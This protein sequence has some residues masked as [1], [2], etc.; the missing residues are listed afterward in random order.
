MQ[1][2]AFTRELTFSSSASG[3]EAD[4][5][6]RPSLCENSG[7]TPSAAAGWAEISPSV[8]HSA[9]F[10]SFQDNSLSGGR[11]PRVFPHSLDP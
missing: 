11:C 5:R 8:R 6:F 3:K 1:M 4:D 9:N 2:C 10:A 7:Q